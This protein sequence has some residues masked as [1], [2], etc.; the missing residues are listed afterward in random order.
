MLE[1]IDNEKKQ[2]NPYDP[3]DLQIASIWGRSVAAAL[4][5]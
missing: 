3:Q 5:A 2:K 4:I 1:T